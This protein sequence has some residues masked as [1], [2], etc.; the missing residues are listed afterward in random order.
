MANAVS[1]LRKVLQDHDGEITLTQIAEKCDLRTNEISMALCY[2]K[3]QRYV[4]R[5]RI[6]SV[7]RMGRKE[8][9]NYTY[10]SSRLAA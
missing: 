1:T 8:V 2:L 3:K 9:W 4:T 6:Q 10:S 5:S 7:I